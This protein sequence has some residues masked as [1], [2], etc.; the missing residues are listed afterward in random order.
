[1][2]DCL[3]RVK[4]LSC[5]CARAVAFVDSVALSST[6]R[7]ITTVL[8]RRSLYGFSP[9]AMSAV[10][11][12]TDDPD[13]SPMRTTRVV[14]SSASRDIVTAPGNAATAMSA[15]A[16]RRTITA[17]GVATNSEA[18]GPASRTTPLV[19]WPES[20]HSAPTVSHT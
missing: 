9:P 10:P 3:G 20:F 13:A 1:M 19:A 18:C 5:S 17:R 7:F 8:L 11:V 6:N 16:S 14:K 12:T 4:R 15:P 2:T